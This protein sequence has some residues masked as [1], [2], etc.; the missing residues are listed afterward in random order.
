MLSALR[1]ELK[2]FNALIILRLCMC[3]LRFIK[4]RNPNPFLLEMEAIY[5]DPTSLNGVITPAPLIEIAFC[6]D[7]L[8]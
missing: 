5:G 1:F 3:A 2:Q 7:K 4:N 6:R 8:T